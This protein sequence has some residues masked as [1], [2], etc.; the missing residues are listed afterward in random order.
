M[1]QAHHMNPAVARE[2]V[3]FEQAPKEVLFLVS[4]QLLSEPVRTPWHYRTFLSKTCEPI[5][6][7]RWLRNLGTTN[8]VFFLVAHPRKHLSLNVGRCWGVFLPIVSQG[9]SALSFIIHI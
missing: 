3:F 1:N 5:D 6:G 2:F 9:L 8:E 7:L 4:A